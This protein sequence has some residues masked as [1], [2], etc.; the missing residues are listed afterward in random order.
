VATQRPEPRWILAACVPVFFAV[1]PT[2]ALALQGQVITPVTIVGPVTGQSIQF[3][4][5]LPPG[6]DNGLR[7]YPVV[8]H[9]H[10]LGGRHDSPNNVDAVTRSH[11]AAVAAGLIRPV[12]IVFPDGDVDT[13]WADT[14]DGTRPVETQ[15]VHEILPYVDAN[16][17]T[18]PMRTQRAMQGFSMGGFGAAKFASKFPHLFSSSVIYD[19]ALRTWSGLLQVHPAL[20]ATVFGNDEVYFDQYSPRHW[21][22]QNAARLTFPVP[23][24]QVVGSLVA[25]NQSFHDL[26]LAHGV[27]AAYV[28]TSCGHDLDCL[29]KAGGADSWAFIADSFGWPTPPTPARMPTRITR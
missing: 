20:A 6:Y 22:S 9:L 5:Y 21:V 4:L 27:T 11:E 13:F 7:R 8:Y 17:R 14:I 26:L 10:G 28:K 3:S 19:G 2:P 12:I 23:F 25:P 15:V 24:R 18:R 29:L 16:Y 1:S